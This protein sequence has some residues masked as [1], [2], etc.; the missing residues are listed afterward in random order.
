MKFEKTKLLQVRDNIDRYLK[1]VETEEKN[2]YE[3]LALSFKNSQVMIDRILAKLEGDKTYETVANLLNGLKGDFTE[4]IKATKVDLA[5]LGDN[6][7]GLTESIIQTYS[8]KEIVASLNRLEKLL[9]KKPETK[10][11]VK[12]RTD[13]IIKASREYKLF[14][15]FNMMHYLVNNFSSSLPIFALS[16]FFSTENAGLYAVAFTII[17]RPV[18]L[19]TSSLG[20]VFSQRAIVKFNENKDIM[21]EVKRLISGLIQIGILPFTVAA[22]AGPSIFSLIL[23]ENVLKFL[24]VLSFIMVILEL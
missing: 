2:R 14:P 23:G 19:F 3:R 11:E 22:I 1:K 10:K 21:N 16:S 18:N 9:E 6:I 20:Q 17:F 24:D 7:K 15:K 4:A 5:P 12:D 13:E 8:S